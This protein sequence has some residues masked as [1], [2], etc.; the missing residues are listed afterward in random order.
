[1]KHINLLEKVQERATRFVDGFAN[2]EYS[3]RLRI[4]KLPTLAHRR[5]RG[6]MIE[7]WKHFNT[8][9]KTTLSESF[10]HKH[11]ASRR[12]NFQLFHNKSHYGE[13]GV[14]WGDT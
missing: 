6:D 5:K 10:K 2:L 9:D 11:R 3:E 14:G 8:Y 4:L 12:H 13:R 1:M 7:G